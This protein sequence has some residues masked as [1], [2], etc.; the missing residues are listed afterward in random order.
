MTF[1]LPHWLL[2]E[3]GLS[4][5]ALSLGRLPQAPDW[6]GLGSCWPLYSAGQAE[7][8]GFLLLVLL[9]G[10]GNVWFYTDQVSQHAGM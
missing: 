3:P 5:G 6:D 4:L 8:L 7:T 1:L 10:P 2:R 9:I